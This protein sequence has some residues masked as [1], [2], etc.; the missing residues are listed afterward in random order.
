[1]TEYPAAESLKDGDIFIVD[2][3]ITKKISFETLMAEVQKRIQFPEQP[4]PADYQSVESV[5]NTDNFI[6]NDGENKKINFQK[7]MTKIQN[8]IQ[9]PEPTIPDID[10]YQIVEKAAKSNYIIRNSIYR[11]NN[12]GANITNQVKTSIE[13]NSFDNLFIGDYWEVNGIKFRIAHFNYFTPYA[14]SDRSEYT[15]NINNHIIVVPDECL[16]ADKALS[17]GTDLMNEASGNTI[18]SPIDAELISISGNKDY[19]PELYNFLIHFCKI[20][21]MTYQGWFN[22]TNK[23]TREFY[24]SWWRGFPMSS[25]M[26]FDKHKSVIQTY[27]T[28]DNIFSYMGSIMD[29]QLSLFSLNPKLIKSNKRYWLIDSSGYKVNL[30]VNVGGYIRTDT[31]TKEYGIRPCF[32]LT[33]SESTKLTY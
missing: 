31:N 10:Y 33:K 6:I 23:I 28:G 7:L 19:M 9:F 5:Q 1:M 18:R 11:G 32:I 27:R 2:D 12:L 8:S 15:S 24:Y 16:G 29:K 25:H 30:Y 3:G 4:D 21:N 22:S 14:M 17:D 26:L 13:N 20:N